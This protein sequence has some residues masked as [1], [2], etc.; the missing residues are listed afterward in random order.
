MNNRNP[1]SRR[2]ALIGAAVSTAALALPLVARAAAGNV[3]S[4][5]SAMLARHRAARAALDASNAVLDPI[6]NAYLEAEAGDPIM[7]RMPGFRFQYGQRRFFGTHPDTIREFYAANYGMLS[8]KSG[9]RPAPDG[10]SWI[11][12]DYSADQ[13]RDL[14]LAL[15]SFAA[16][17]E[18]ATKR[19]EAMGL[20]EAERRSDECNDALEASWLALLNYAPRTIAEVRE[21]AA[22][23]ISIAAADPVQLD[24]EHMALFLQ[25]LAA[26]A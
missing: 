22:A 4:P 13:E 19:S 23:V 12:T 18:A 26:G 9:A 11:F 20:R 7:V 6:W 1:I 10:N 8:G 5:I 2:A 21:K 3:P 25:S 14:A 17:S 15:E 16:A 24:D